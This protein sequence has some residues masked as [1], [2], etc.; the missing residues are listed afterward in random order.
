[1]RNTPFD[2][3]GYTT[4]RRLARQLLRAYEARIDELLGKLSP[5]NHALMVEIA[6][7]PEGIRG[8]GHVR[9]AHAEAAREKE[10][11][12]LQALRVGHAPPE[13]A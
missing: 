13:A 11:E 5:E 3:F 6:S 8:Y 9:V 10:A 2:P 12:L 7:I 1:L 4:D